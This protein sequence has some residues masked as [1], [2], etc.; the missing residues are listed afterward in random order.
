MP[1]ATQH[2]LSKDRTAQLP[3][4]H[5]RPHHDTS[6]HSNPH[7]IHASTN[8][9]A[10]MH[11]V[12]EGKLHQMKSK[13]RCQES[14]VQQCQEQRAARSAAQKALWQLRD[15]LQQ[16]QLKPATG[17]G[18]WPRTLAQK[19]GVMRN[20]LSS[21]EASHLLHNTA[22]GKGRPRKKSGYCCTACPAHEQQGMLFDCTRTHASH[23]CHEAVRQ[24]FRP[25][26]PHT[27]PR[28]SSRGQGGSQL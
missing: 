16:Q 1:A 5:L 27:L 26:K 11:R 2:R 15:S 19:Q 23:T 18:S 13:V 10:G 7:I 25:H 9:C 28:K 14:Q 3:Q 24:A 21:P 12:W 6:A 4:V 8:R 17:L 20:K 22:G